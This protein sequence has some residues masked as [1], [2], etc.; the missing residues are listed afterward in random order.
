MFSKH[1]YSTYFRRMCLHVFTP[2]N[3]GLG[4][5]SHAHGKLSMTCRPANHAHILSWTK[6]F[7]FP[8]FSN[9]FLVIILE[10][11]MWNLCTIFS[12]FVLHLNIIQQSNIFLYYFYKKSS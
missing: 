6:G 5:T 8:G 11:E 7:N 3:T 10:S 1:E 9:V 2:Q 12:Y 4:K